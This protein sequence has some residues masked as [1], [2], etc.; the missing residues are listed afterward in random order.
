[1]EKE[2]KKTYYIGIL[3]PSGESCISTGPTNVAKFI[4]VDR[5]TIYNN[6]GQQ[7]YYQC[8]KYILCKTTRFYKMDRK[9]V[10]PHVINKKIIQVQ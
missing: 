7:S 1:M 5:R 3:L 2:A 6:L 8:V 4:G 9:V 10:E